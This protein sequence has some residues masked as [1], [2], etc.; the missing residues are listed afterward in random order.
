[1]STTTQFKTS[2][3][4]Q[5]LLLKDEIN[6]LKANLIEYKKERK[7]E[8]EEFKTKTTDHIDKIEK[9]LDILNDFIKR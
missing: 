5:R 8:W 3:K 9:S 4:K 2:L 1:M 6:L 7:L